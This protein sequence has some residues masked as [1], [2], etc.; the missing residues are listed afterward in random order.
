[1]ETSV[2]RRPFTRDAGSVNVE[3]SFAMFRVMTCITVAL[4]ACATATKGEDRTDARVDRDGPDGPRPVDAAQGDCSSTDTC[5]GAMMLGSVSGDTGA[6]KLTAMGYRSAWFR[7][8]VTEDNAGISGLAL[9]VSAQLTP[10][11]SAGFD[12]FV[13]VN[14]ASNVVEC[15]T[16]LGTASTDGDVKLTKAMWGEAGLSNGIDD[17]RDVSIEVRPVSGPCVAGQMWQLEVAGNWI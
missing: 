9:R 17:G 11:A 12:V 10:P 13:Y 2:W 7:V 4:A 5:L 1:M 16:P 14:A 6:Q 15:T 3:G 8:R